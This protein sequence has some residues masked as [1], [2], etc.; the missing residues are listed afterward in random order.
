MDE[1]GSDYIWDST[2]TY[3]YT[4]GTW[5]MAKAKLPTALQLLSA[6]N[7]DNRVLLFG[8]IW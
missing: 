6:T 3:D 7:I 5:V 8:M 2:E 4:V 1:Y